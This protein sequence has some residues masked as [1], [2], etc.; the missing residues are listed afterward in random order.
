[1][2]HSIRQTVYLAALTAVCALAGPQSLMAES[3]GDVLRESGWDRVLGSWEGIDARG[4][5]NVVTYAWRFEDRLIEATGRRDGTESVALMGRNPKTGQIY[6]VGAD[7]NGGGS[8]G[9]WSQEEGD[10]V[11]GLRYV[12][13]EGLEGGM[14]IRHHLEDDDTMVV[15]I[16]GPEPL[17]FTMKRVGSRGAARAVRTTGTGAQR[18][19]EGVFTEGR[20]VVY[21]D[22]PI[23]NFDG[24]DNLMIEA[25][26]LE[27]GYLE[28]LKQYGACHARLLAQ[29]D[30]DKDGRISETEGDAVRKLAFEIADLLRNDR[31]GDWKVDADEADQAWE[32]VTEQCERHNEGSLKRFDKNQDG[33]LSQEE[34]A[35][36]RNTIQEWRA[37]DGR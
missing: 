1:M 26:E 5:T 30:A 37:R 4:A 31:N 28:M 16:E 19:R 35:A 25:Q 20:T 9:A 17:S 29:F 10:A 14:R 34:T 15:T 7:S 3:L 18:R 6:H 11:L 22:T 32:R 24:N 2:M 33:V 12:T 8:M 21:V 36:A 23:R 27:A 13:G